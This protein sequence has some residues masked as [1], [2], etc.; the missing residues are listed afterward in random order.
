MFD[1]HIVLLSNGNWA[2][3]IIPIPITHDDRDYLVELINF[4]LSTSE[5]R[6]QL[7]GTNDPARSQKIPGE[8]SSES[9]TKS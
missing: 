3:I 8:P 7:M 1:Q 9:E 4:A 6:S 5:K 2:H